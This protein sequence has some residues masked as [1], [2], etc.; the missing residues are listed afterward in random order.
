MVSGQESTC[1]CRGHRTNPWSGKIPRASGQLSP[2][3]KA[4]SPRALEALLCDQRSH[5]S[6]TPVPS[7]QGE[8]PLAAARAK[9]ESSDKD[10][11][12]PKVS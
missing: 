7:N 8:P 2:C 6:E 12:Q 1:Q 11:A 10:P 4:C 9:S 3:L 5:C